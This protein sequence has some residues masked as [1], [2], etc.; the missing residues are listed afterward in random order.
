MH[1]RLYNLPFSALLFMAI[2]LFACHD[3]GH[4]PADYSMDSAQNLNKTKSVNS[5]VARTHADF[6][7][8]TYAHGLY[9]TKA[10]ELALTQSANDDVKELAL[11]LITEYAQMNKNIVGLGNRKSISLPGD[12]GG[13]AA[14]RLDSLA[15]LKGAAFD[16]AYLDQLGSDQVES[17]ELL[18]QA[19]QSNDSLI[20]QWAD[21]TLSR[22]K[23]I[24]EMV[25][26]CQ[27]KLDSH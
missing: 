4:H 13:M 9:A 7:M 22:M 1:W 24:M 16:V 6:L 17:I 26:S 5:P 3:T 23:G 25:K 10:S 11:G 14:R 15:S 27:S 19:G 8:R 20:V 12:L 21:S 18:E 2:F